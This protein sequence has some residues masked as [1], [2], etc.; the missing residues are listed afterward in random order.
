MIGQYE[1]SLFAF[2]EALKLYE[3]KNSKEPEVGECWF[4]LGNALLNLNREEEALDCFVKT[5]DFDIEK[6]VQIKVQ[7]AEGR[8]L[9]YKKKAEA[10]DKFQSCLELIGNNKGHE[11]YL[12]SLYHL[13]SNQQIHKLYP[14]A[15]DSL[16]QIIDTECN[17]KCVFEERGKA[18][19]FNEDYS[20]ALK[21]F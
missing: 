11:L 2:E 3:S 7:Y 6:K 18:Y 5:L 17:D 1:Q 14:D 13:A 16:T 19:L 4:N 20:E 21:D 15:I 9:E 8:A 12:S 10:I